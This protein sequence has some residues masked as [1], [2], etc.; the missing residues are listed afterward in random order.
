MPTLLL[1]PGMPYFLLAL[2][3]ALLAALGLALRPRQ[4]FVPGD[5]AP[6]IIAGSR[7]LIGQIAGGAL[8]TLLAL[9]A[10]I[11]N[12]T[13]TA[14]ALLLAFAL[15]SYLGLGVVVPR[16]P[17][18][19]RAREAAALRRLTPGL[20]AFVRVALGSFEAPIAIL[21]RYVERP[22]PAWAPMQALVGEALQLSLDQR[23][24]PFAALAAA[25]RPRGC[26]ELNDVA[27]ALAQAEAEGGPIEQVLAAQQ[28]TLEL[29]LQGEFRRMLR[30][31]TL[32]LLLLVAISLVVGILINLLFVMTGGGAVFARFG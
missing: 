14:L 4:A 32:Y 15:A 5:A 12:A 26:R 21:R 20:I 6:H 2:A 7:L 16:R 31:R 29:I 30:R 19:Q 8:A 24:R 18:V 3:G 22:H 13:G 27:E 9:T 17:A 23:M 28:H 11:S 25:A 10:L 1:V